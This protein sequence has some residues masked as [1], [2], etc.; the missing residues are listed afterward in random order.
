[1]RKDHTL[2]YGLS[3]FMKKLKKLIGFY[4][5]NLVLYSLFKTINIKTFLS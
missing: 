3:Y 5:D 1:L 4:K 2:K